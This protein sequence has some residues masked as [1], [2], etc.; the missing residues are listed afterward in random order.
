M[1]CGPPGAAC[2]RHAPP[3]TRRCHPPKLRL[4][5][6]PIRLRAARIHPNGSA[7]AERDRGQ[8][9]GW[10]QTLLGSRRVEGEVG[11]RVCRAVDAGRRGSGVPRPSHAPWPA[12]ATTV[13]C[14]VPASTA[15]SALR[16]IRRRCRG[17][18]ASGGR[19]DGTQTPP[20][21]PDRAGA[22]RRGAG[23]AQGR[24]RASRAETGGWGRAGQPHVW[25][26]AKMF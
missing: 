20:L 25:G 17:A 16:A 4:A 24:A 14:A 7:N 19:T 18:Q 9:R 10:R 1:R 13:G 23:A 3:P 2:R 5:G 21:R 15:S 26:R 22:W 12:A 11:E 8:L 6:R